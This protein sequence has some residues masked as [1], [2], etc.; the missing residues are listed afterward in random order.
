VV[1]AAQRDEVV[2]IGEAVALPGLQVLGM[3]VVTVVG[4]LLNA[5]LT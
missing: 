2:E 1:V 3:W 5:V 4:V